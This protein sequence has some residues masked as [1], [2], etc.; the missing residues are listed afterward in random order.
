MK[1]LLEEADFDA[2]KLHELESLVRS[3]E[4]LQLEFKRRITDAEKVVSEMCAFANTSGGKLLVG[5]ND[6]KGIPGVKFPEDESYTLQNTIAKHCKPLLKYKESVIQ[7]APNR[8]V[9]QYDIPE[10][11]RKPQ[12][13]I[14]KEGIKKVY[15][16]H[17]DKTVQASPEM[18]EVI[19]R[20][21]SKRNIRFDYGQHE[22]LLMKYLQ[23]NPYIT[24]SQYLELTNQKRFSGSRKLVTLVL[25]NVLQI[26]PTERGDQYS[27]HHSFAS[28]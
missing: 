5:V 13:F 9:L 22:E 12:F 1:K 20:K 15:V 7:V 24:L 28:A 11:R 27:L 2:R 8:F 3:G 25:A 19:K 26:T 4:G 21:R 23:Q 17:E 16:R 18:K 6:D 10:S 14:N